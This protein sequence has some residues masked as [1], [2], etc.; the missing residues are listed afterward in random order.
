MLTDRKRVNR[1]SI[2]VSGTL[3]KLSVYLQPTGTSGQQVLRGVIYADQGGAP[4]GLLGVTNEITFH[5]TDTAGW[6]DLSFPAGISVQPGTYWIGM[7][8]GSTSYIAAFRWT[9]VAGSRAYNANPYASGPSSV[10]GT[11]S[12]DAE[13]MSIYATYSMP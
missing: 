9:S 13:Q 8:S 10:F 12:T 7:M 2:G 3:T 4:G 1:Y 5:S 11:A 6:Y